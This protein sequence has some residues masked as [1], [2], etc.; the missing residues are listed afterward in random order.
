MCVCVCVCRAITLTTRCSQGSDATLLLLSGLLFILTHA[1]ISPACAQQNGQ[2]G[3]TDS[4]W[5]MP[6]TRSENCPTQAEPRAARSCKLTVAMAGPEAKGNQDWWC[7]QLRVVSCAFS[8]ATGVA[9]TAVP[10]MHLLQRH[11]YCRLSCN[12]SARSHDHVAHTVFCAAISLV[13]TCMFPH[14]NAPSVRRHT[15]QL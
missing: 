7:V 9:S 5:H 11:S 6:S 8:A 1:P 10:N 4:A 3:D 2:G 14:T 13:S 15:A 12:V